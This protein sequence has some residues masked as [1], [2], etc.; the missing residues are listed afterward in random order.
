MAQTGGRLARKESDQGAIIISSYV[1]YF[2]VHFMG[3]VKAHQLLLAFGRGLC[4]TALMWW[5]V[6]LVDW[7][8]QGINSLQVFGF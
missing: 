1:S 2:Q 6:C 5:S 8:C 3:K 7:T 4:F